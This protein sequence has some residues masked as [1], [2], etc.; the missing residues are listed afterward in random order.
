MAQLAGAVPMVDAV[1]Q[2]PAVA[3]EAGDDKALEL[4]RG[5]HG[6]KVALEGVMGPPAV[7]ALP[8]AGA[9]LIGGDKLG[10][11]GIA[12]FPQFIHPIC[13]G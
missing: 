11:P 1:I 13:R 7:E 3:L 10:Q 2:E 8:G 4:L 9:L 5:D 6:G 12:L